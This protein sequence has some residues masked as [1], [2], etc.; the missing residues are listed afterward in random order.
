MSV[1]IRLSRAGK[2]HVPYH[3]LVVVDSR[4]KRDGAIIANIGTYD[5]LKSTVVQFDEQVYNQWILKGAQPSDSA[6]KIYNQFKK[7]GTTAP[8]K[9]AKSVKT[10]A[11]ESAKKVE[12]Q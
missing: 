2:K 8:E 6:K 9:K 4:K 1:K 11:Q 3:R 10:K 5:A 12:V 7:I